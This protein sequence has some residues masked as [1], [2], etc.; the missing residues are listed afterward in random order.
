MNPTPSGRLFLIWREP[1]SR[2]QYP[3]GE[4]SFDGDQYRFSYD[5]G[6]LRVAE[7]HGFSLTSLPLVAAFPER[8]ETYTSTDLFSAV[9]HRLPDPR[10][11]DYG[12]LLARLGLS[13]ESH[14]FQILRK[15]RGRLATDELS[16]E[17]TPTRTAEGL[18]IKC[19][20]SGWR[21]YS[22]ESVVKDLAIGDSVELE[23]D[24]SN[25]FDPHAVKVCGPQNKMLG[26][27]PVYDSAE[28]A[29]ALSTARRVSATITE[30]NPPPL[31]ST[32]RLRIR[33]VIAPRPHAREK[34]VHPAFPWVTPRCSDGVVGV[35]R[36]RPAK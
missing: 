23:R 9:A 2:A 5:T 17:E 36:G 16:F 7:R 4:L 18:I 35:F 21:F 11:P 12:K 29:H 22:G 27:I 8:D 31:P 13:R 34:M 6:A 33:I 19:Y 14:P 10:R 15:T 25:R 3:I 30:I 28:S 24:Q 26:F 20:V 32:D 1:L